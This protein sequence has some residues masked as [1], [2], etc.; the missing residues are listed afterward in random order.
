MV[1]EELG[2]G[3]SSNFSNLDKWVIYQV[4]T[5]LQFAP[6]QSQARFRFNKAHMGG[7]EPLFENEDALD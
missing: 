7:N 2:R 6:F 5:N 3:E 1:P 4:L